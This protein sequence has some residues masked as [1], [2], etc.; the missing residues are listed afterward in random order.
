MPSSATVTPGRKWHGNQSPENWEGA[1]DLRS[2][3][4]NFQEAFWGTKSQ[5]VHQPQEAKYLML[6]NR[7]RWRYRVQRKSETGWQIHDGWM[8]LRV[9]CPSKHVPP[10]FLILHLIEPAASRWHETWSLVKRPKGPS[11][12]Y[13]ETPHHSALKNGNPIGCRCLD[14]T[15]RRCAI[16]RVHT[17][18]VACSLSCVEVTSPAGCHGAHL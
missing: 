14:G 16:I 12:L 9:T 13:R 7:M 5:S 8:A 6:Q 2:W 3:G 15:E 17:T 4:K 1:F 18:N 11:L 10:H